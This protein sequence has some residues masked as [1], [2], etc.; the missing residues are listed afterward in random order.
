MNS[1]FQN[2]EQV[3]QE[4]LHEKAAVWYISDEFGFKIMVKAPS[5]AIRSVIKGCRVEFLF[6]KDSEHDKPILHNGVRIYDDPVHYMIITGAQRYEREHSS[7]LR[8]IKNEI[9]PI[10]FH[11][12]LSV[13]TATAVVSFTP[14]SRMRI[15][16]LV[17]DKGSLYTGPFD[18]SISRSLDCF[19]YSLDKAKQ[20]NY[21]RDIEVVVI[22]AT[23]SNWQMM[24]NHFIGV[25]D[26]SKVVIN[27]S[28][29]GK[30]FEK[31]VWA[32]LESMFDFDIYLRP[33][34]K[35]KNI[36]R[37]L[38]DILAFSEY[39]IFLVETK[40]LGILNN[41]Q[42]RNMD[43]KVAG[44]QKQISKGIDQLAGAVKKVGEHEIIYD[45]KGATIEFDREL[46]PHCI[47]LVSEL[48]P[49]GEWKPILIKMF[50]TMIDVPMQ[51]HLMD[52]T[53]FMRY[54]GY[55]KHNKH[56]F[57]YF[58]MERTNDLVKHQTV[59]INLHV[60]RGHEAENY[61]HSDE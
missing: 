41:D 54:V 17:G 50:Q 33:Q 34:V 1:N 3:W 46:L 53:E 19:V 15:L 26:Q 52:L 21:A 23:L 6:G 29:E 35:H 59:H 55:S 44:I 45:S 42:E 14:A 58:L 25:N 49:F 8:I 28:S 12:E 30:V 31:Q 7:L 47:V 2:A 51:L 32:S 57:D 16:K 11:N 39:G 20:F 60:E 24:T 36:S 9:I 56:T 22:E 38:T 13:C 18:D 10:H 4:L 37:E 27:D 61:D 48:L 43:R 40:A 5:S